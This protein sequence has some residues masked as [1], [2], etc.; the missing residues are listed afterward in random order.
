MLTHV[1]ETEED[2]REAAAVL[3]ELRRQRAEIRAA[4]SSLEAA[5]NRKVEIPT[6]EQ[7]V[8]ML[9]DFGQIL[10]AA[11]GGELGDDA[12]RA[13]AIIAQLTGGRIELCQCGERK[14][15]RG[16]LQGRFISRL[17]SVASEMLT[18]IPVGF[19]DDGIEV[20]IDFRHPVPYDA[21]AE[22]AKELYDKGLLG[23]Q[24]A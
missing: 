21:E 19:S 17:P 5:S 4:I 22:L 11:A 6:E 8:A 7:V 18:G 15:Q 3:A 10:T 12:G 14:A 20:T 23:T 1:G 13:R 16:W 24:I 2:E 9:D